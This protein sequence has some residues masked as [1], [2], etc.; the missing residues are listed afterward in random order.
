[1]AATNPTS[2][3]KPMH[4]P[5][6]VA[7]VAALV[8]VGTACYPSPAAAQAR[9]SDSSI[10][11]HGIQAGQKVRIQLLT[12]NTWEGQFSQWVD[13]SRFRLAGDS[14]S[15]QLATV[16]TLHVRGRATKDGAVAG[17]F[18]LGMFTAAAAQSLCGAYGTC[19]SR[20]GTWSLIIGGAGGAAVGGIVGALIGSAFP[21][22]KERYR[23]NLAR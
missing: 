3:A 4:L 21:A 20:D 19:S 22:W 7:V 2:L 12:G 10:A 9:L 15:I 17:A 8:V 11:L 16:R 13:P 1:V 6:N 14:A 23:S 18:L 5:K